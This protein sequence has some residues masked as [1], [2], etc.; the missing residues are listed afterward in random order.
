MVDQLVAHYSFDDGTASSD[1]GTGTGRGDSSLDGTITGATA[2]TGMFGTGALAFDGA[3]DYVDFPS[4]VTADI[5]GTSDRTVCL[6]VQRDTTDWQ[7]GVFFCYGD[8]D[9]AFGSFTLK[10]NCCSENVFVERHG[11]DNNYD[12]AGSGDYEISG[13]DDGG[14]HHV[15]MTAQDKGGGAYDVITTI[16]FDGVGRSFNNLELDTQSTN[17]LR[18]GAH[19]GDAGW[20]FTGSLDELYVY[21]GLLVSTDIKDLYEFDPDYELNTVHGGNGDDTITVIGAR[22]Q[23]IFGGAGDDVIIADGDDNTKFYGGDG[24]DDITLNGQSTRYVYGGDGDDTITA[25]GYKNYR[26]YG[27]AGDDDI[28]INTDDANAF[29]A[30]DFATGDDTIVDKLV[31]GGDGDDTISVN[32]GHNYGICL[33]YTSPSPRD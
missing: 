14:W 30:P 17:A 16:Y 20:K 28:T 13:F 18:I 10:S 24:D 23:G 26:F 6:W 31:D 7:D 11:N 1:D 15:C 22:N 33:L 27:G 3:D 19:L 2:T 8:D 21:S 12:E 29:V 9:T 25:T 32:G 5:L 4:A